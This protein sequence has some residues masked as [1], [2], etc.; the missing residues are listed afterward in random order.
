LVVWYDVLFQ[1]SVVSKSVQSQ[2][3][4]V[5]KS[6]ELIEGCHE[7]LKEYKEN[8]SQRA[9]S[10]ATELAIDLEVEP[11]FQNV[12]RI[13]YVKCNF[14]YEAHDEPIMTP[15]KKFEIEFFNT[16]LDAALMSLKEKFEQLH[17]HAETWGFLYKINELPKKEE[18]IKHCAGFNCCFGCRSKELLCVMN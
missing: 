15:E 11:E 3:F 17:Q 13:R 2:K 1:I 18:L 6:V 8:G 7:F 10:A 5:Y 4:D 14:D 16:L 9:T 12:K